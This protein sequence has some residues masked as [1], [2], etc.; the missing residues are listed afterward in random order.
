MGMRIHSVALASVLLAACTFRLEPLSSTELDTWGTGDA[1]ASPD[2]TPFA[3]PDGSTP[4]ADTG[5]SPGDAQSG[6]AAPPTTAGQ[7]YAA[8][9]QAY[10]QRCSTYVVT[11]AEARSIA[12]RIDFQYERSRA[13][14]DYGSAIAECTAWLGGDTCGNSPPAC[15][16][17][18]VLGGALNGAQCEFGT[19]CQSGACSATSNSCG[20]CIDAVAPGQSCG[21]AASACG[22]RAGCL[23]GRCVARSYAAEGADCSASGVVCNEGLQCAAATR[24]CVRPA[25]AGSACSTDDDCNL[26]G[27]FACRANVCA[28]RPGLGEACSAALACTAGLACDAQSSLCRAPR[29]DVA[30]GADCDA[31]DRCAAGAACLPS[32]SGSQCQSLVEDGGAC[33]ADSPCAGLRSICN[34][35]GKCSPIAT[36]CAP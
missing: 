10:F 29:S 19:E 5:L 32:A 7:R 24:T 11:Q 34:S 18:Q 20:A 12:A 35:S 36:S 31:L 9:A 22:P 6:D 16:L 33:S 14:S 4:T 21:S 25:A 30:R 23:A 3:G 2:A 15:D 13:T 1:S 8:S 17:D 27:R 26:S 28:P